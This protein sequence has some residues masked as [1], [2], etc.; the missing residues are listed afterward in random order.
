MSANKFRDRIRIESGGTGKDPT[1]GTPIEAPWVPFVEVWAEIQDLAPSKSESQDH[2]IRLARDSTRIRI[3][4]LPG[5]LPTMRIVE[6]TGQ[7]RTLS[8]I[9]GPASIFNGREIELVA[10]RFSS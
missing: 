6:L 1:Y 3:R 8:I 5:I 2:G 7:M 10:E 9:G 4:F